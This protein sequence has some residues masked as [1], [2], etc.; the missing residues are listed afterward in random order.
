MIKCLAKAKCTGVNLKNRNEISPLYVVSPCAE[1]TL[2]KCSVPSEE[3]TAV[4]D[5]LVHWSYLYVC[6]IEYF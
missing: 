4:E 2:N 3:Q 6:P 1:L 5:Y